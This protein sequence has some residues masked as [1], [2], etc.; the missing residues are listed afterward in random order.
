MSKLDNM[1]KQFESNNINVI[2]YYLVLGIKKDVTKKEIKKA[3]IK[4]IHPYNKKSPLSDTDKQD[5]KLVKAAKFVLLDNELR[6]LYDNIV[7][8][9][10]KYFHDDDKI[11]SDAIG[12]R[13]FNLKNII[14]IPHNNFKN[15]V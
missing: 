12:N 4:R 14:N 1:D 3:Y 5:I 9:K 7:D 6:E 8:S 2:N 10:N 13:I 15:K 11:K